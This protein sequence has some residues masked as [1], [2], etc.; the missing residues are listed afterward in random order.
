MIDRL[1]SFS[2]RQ[3]VLVGLLAVLLTGAGI[4]SA[5]HLPID[6]VPDITPVQVMINT[7]VSALAP[8]EVERLVTYPIEVEMSGLPRLEFTRSLS[9]YA[10]SQVVL[11]FR[12]GTDPYWARQLAAERLQTA[13]D[14]LPPGLAEPELGPITSGLGEIYF[15]TV[16]P[17]PGSKLTLDDA[18][19]VQD[20]IVKPQ[21]RTVPGVTEVATIGGDV[22]QFQV[23]PDL[24]RLRAY[25]LSLDDLAH[26][27]ESN[28]ANA[29]GAYIERNDEQVSVRAVGRVASMNELGE[30]V[31]AVRNGIT[32]H[33]R[34]VA[35]LANGHA[36]RAGMAMHDGRETVLGS[37]LMLMGENSREVARRVERRIADVRASLPAGLQITPVYSRTT[38][39]EQ[40]IRTVAKNLLHGGL[41]VFVVLLLTL[42]HIRASTVV[43]LAIPLSMMF[44]VI[45]MEYGGVSA[46]L[47]S[48]GAIDFGLIVDGAVV[49]AENLVR[50][51]TLLREKVDRPLTR[52]ERREASIQACREMARPVSFA[53][54]IIIIV[55]LPILTLQGTEG[56][57]FR[58]MALTVV[59]ALTGS[60]L[61]ALTLVPVLASLV[62]DGKK[63]RHENVVMAAATRVYRPVLGWAMRWRVP[64]LL[65]A[66]APLALAA[67]L[68]PRLGAEFLPRLEEGAIDVTAIKL[69]SA[70]LSH[71]LE[72]DKQVFAVLRRF[73]D[74]EHIFSHA[75]SGDITTDPMPAN[76]TDIMCMVKPRE[77]WTT[78]R[79]QEGLVEA[80]GKELR[81][82]V[83]GCG[84]GFT[85]PIED[86]FN[87]LIAGIRTDVGIMV[88][89]DDFDRL[90]G[91][92]QAVERVARGT[93]GAGEVRF[94][95]ASTAPVLEIRPRREALAAYGLTIDQVNGL[96]STALAGRTLGQVIEGDRRFDIVLRLADADR[97]S[98]DVLRSLPVPTHSALLRLADVA[99]IQFEQTPP[100]L[101]RYQGSRYVVI[102]ADVKGRDLAGFVEDLQARVRAGVHLPAGYHIEYGGEFETY[103]AAR[104][105]LAV[106]VPMALLLIFMLLFAA[107]QSIRQALLVF[108]AVPLA[109]TG[110]VFALWLRGIPFSISAGVGFIAL[111]GVAVLNGVVMISTFN[112]LRVQGVQVPEAVERGS[113]ERLRPVLMTALVAS[114][115]FVP[116]A[117]S[118]GAGAEVQR[119]LATVVIGGLVT[120]TA[121]TLI[122]LPI[123]Y[124][125][126]VKDQPQP[127][128]PET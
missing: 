74:V 68:F 102:E 97:G 84:F 48:L 31:V 99:D 64:A 34:D 2:L 100:T 46:N 77:Q 82:T 7:R 21:V 105:R 4:W 12:E 89:G 52:E 126:L 54:A 42:G 47:M 63:G 22:V 76:D 45:G 15:Y 103:M 107:F 23:I 123:L 19:I 98:L 1:V 79:T 73:P 36:L 121:L 25:D 92:A 110:G 87:D 14:S 62:V 29:G 61:L 113:L 55:Y 53:V 118:T 78:A 37:V 106:V 44:A 95:V 72:I 109:V 124:G 26:A 20:W 56:K 86:R 117:I 65:L 120:S 108:S 88:F 32:I 30:A 83:A 13:R 119:P 111:S 80:I 94:E 24:V 10:F 33:V 11:Q 90:L 49:M 66:A 59:F 35:E 41:L 27:V 8:E 51:L 60:L 125:W 70:A 67:W 39:V 38:L 115:G 43:A 128:P 18:R 104:D 85:Q 16:E 112:R 69:P 40:T 122:V 127:A 28:N 6:A 58:P 101:R 81:R 57:M 116:M 75:G 114:L 17:S 96:V 91:I 9:R 71:C 3:R 50:R 93:R 5:I